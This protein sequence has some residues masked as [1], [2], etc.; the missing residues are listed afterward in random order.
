MTSRMPINSKERAKIH[1][2]KVALCCIFEPGRV[3]IV[4]DHRVPEEQVE[5]SQ[6][7]PPYS[8]MPERFTCTLTFMMD[9]TR[10]RIRRPVTMHNFSC[11][12]GRFLTFIL[13]FTSVWEK[14]PAF[15]FSCAIYR[16]HTQ[17]IP[18]SQCQPQCCDELHHERYISLL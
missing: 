6:T 3:G 1:S 18:A 16:H 12:A 8:K 2:G 17:R 13:P 5:N 9:E 7:S 14:R 10:Y 11:V 15:T 4:G